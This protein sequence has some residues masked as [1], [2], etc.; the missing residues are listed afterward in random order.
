MTVGYIRSES[1]GVP[2]SRGAASLRRQ[3]FPWKPT[4][5]QRPRTWKMPAGKEANVRSQPAEGSPSLRRRREVRAGAGGRGQWWE[6]AAQSCLGA[7]AGLAS[8]AGA[9]VPRQPPPSHTSSTSSCLQVAH[10]QPEEAAQGSPRQPSSHHGIKLPPARYPERFRPLLIQQA[11]VGSPREM[12]PNVFPTPGGADGQAGGAGGSKLSPPCRAPQAARACRGCSGQWPWAVGGQ[13]LSP[14][15]SMS[16]QQLPA[17]LSL[18]LG[19]A[20]G[21]NCPSSASWDVGTRD[22]ITQP[23]SLAS[24]ADGQTAAPSGAALPQRVETGAHTPSD[25]VSLGGQGKDTHGPYVSKL[26]FGQEALP[27]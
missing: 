23:L 19:L 22:T 24:L 9:A 1:P 11:Q 18:A 20:G 21:P 17:G 14:A 25:T 27:S 8:T 4:A 26:P 7:R 10:R 12:G 6:G 3:Q 15:G 16:R 13:S 2:Q 5:V